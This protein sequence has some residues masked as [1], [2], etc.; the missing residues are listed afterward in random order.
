[1]GNSLQDQLLK[2]GLAS[3]KQAKKAAAGKAPKKRGK[4]GQQGSVLSES[5]RSAR[6]SMSEKAEQD[7][8]LNRQRK[9]EADRKAL[10]VQIRQL[11]EQNRVPRD[12]GEVGYN[13]VDDGRIRKVFVTPEIQAKLGSGRLAISK[14]DGAYEVVPIDVA[15]KIQARD[16]DCVIAREATE[17][18]AAE[19]DPYRE[20]QVPDD[21]TW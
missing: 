1:M 2:A 10:L 4:K 7:R 17:P 12:G 11:I 19:D 16:A 14:F 9:A 20:Y 18:R 3:E 5:A 6:K 13:F 15:E 8:A 21:L